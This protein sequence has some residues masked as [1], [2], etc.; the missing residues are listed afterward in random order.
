MFSTDN[1][2]GNP[3]YIDSQKK[4][5]IIRT[6]IYFF[7]SFSL[8]LAGYITTQKRENLL[9]VVAV[10]GCLPACKSLVGAIMF[11]RYK[12][13]P[14]ETVNLICSHTGQ[15]NGLFDMVFTSEKKTFVISHLVVHG[16]TICGYSSQPD[17]PEKDF[18]VH[19][20]G[21]L[22]SD[23]HKNYTVKVFTDLQKYTDR[24]G[25]LQELD[26]ENKYVNDVLHT[27]KSVAL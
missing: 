9:T 27:L 13:C 10:V 21:I 17:F 19:I 12:S 3:G 18:Q 11:L 2:K 4:Y 8:F 23:G 16:N 1:W 14:R 22:K 24:L 26:V 20:E 6:I 25:Q 5:E 15:L 7:I